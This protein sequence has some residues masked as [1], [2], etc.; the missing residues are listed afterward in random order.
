MATAAERARKRDPGPDWRETLRDSLRLFGLRVI[1][2]VMTGGSIALALALATHEPV[3]PSFSTAAGGPP[4]N[5]VGSFGSYSS[6][7]LLMLFGLASVLVLPV[8]AI[9]GVR[10]LRGDGP[11][12]LGRALLISMLGMVLVGIAAGMMSGSAVSGL[13][14]GWGGVLGLGGAKG[15]DS[16][17]SL[18]GNDGVEG[19]LRVA[20]L[21]ILALA[22]L[23]VAYL[24]LA[25]RPEERG[26]MSGLFARDPDKIVKPKR[27][28]VAERDDPD[29]GGAAARPAK[30][31]GQRAG[32]SHRA[33]SEGRA[34]QGQG[35]RC[36][37]DQP[38]IGRQLPAA[39]ARAADPAAAGRQE[40]GRSRGTGAQR[41]PA[42]K[43]A[44]GFPRPRR[45]RRGPPRPGRHDVRTGAGE[46][47]S[48]R[49]A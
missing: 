43:R 49:A 21:S 7:L 13:P 15:V 9:A 24:A 35:R 11:G 40:A 30:R 20:T 2:A 12:R 4:A 17:I 16:L 45:H 34:A 19:P 47:A 28:T 26:W 42:G 27:R 33:C 8:L 10:M 1:G 14:A 32:L 23:V 18:I 41:A 5:W 37:P 39:A 6:D 44:R 22:G 3:D 29:F 25:L 48:R 38:G 46:R 36:C 31:L